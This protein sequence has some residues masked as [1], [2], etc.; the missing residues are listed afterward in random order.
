MSV[1]SGPDEHAANPP[2]TWEVVKRG[3][4]NWHVVDRQGTVLERATT[5]REAERLKAEGSVVR[6]YDRETRWYAGETIP[7]WKSWADCKAEREAIEA[8]RA[9]RRADAGEVR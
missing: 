2:E 4:R 8:R 7:G 3:D 5:R 1:Y 6:L 9:A